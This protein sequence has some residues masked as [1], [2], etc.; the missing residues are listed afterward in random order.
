MSTESGIEPT[1]APATRPTVTRRAGPGDVAALVRLRGLMLT[2]MGL[3][4]SPDEGAWRELAVAWFAGKLGDRDEFAAF[5]VEDP[6]LG[7]VSS[8]VGSCDQHAPGPSNPSGLYGYVSNVSTDPRRRRRGYARA[9]LDALLR[10][11]ETETP[12]RVVNLNA[13]THGLGMYTSLG[14]AAPRYPSLQARLSG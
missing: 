2:D 7:V 6:E 12:V 9:C 8:A 14:F 11:Y 3:V 5:V 4:D 1:A 13:T 10:W